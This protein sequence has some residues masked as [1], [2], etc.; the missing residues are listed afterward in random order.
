MLNQYAVDI[1]T[2]PGNQCLSTSS[3][4]WWNAR[5]FYR[6]AEPQKWA[7]KHLGHTCFFGTF[8]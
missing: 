4:S 3:S 6:N 8:L 5:P 7:A 1:P 2:L